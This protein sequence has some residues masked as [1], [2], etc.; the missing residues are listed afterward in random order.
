MQPICVPHVLKLLVVC[1]GVL[2]MTVALAIAAE[3]GYAANATPAIDN[4]GFIKNPPQE[5]VER[6]PMCDAFLKVEWI[7]G[8][9]RLGYSQYSIFDENGG[10]ILNQ[11][12]AIVHLNY[13]NT[14]YDYSARMLPHQ[15]DHLEGQYV[16]S[17]EE[18]RELYPFFRNAKEVLLREFMPG[19]KYKGRV[20]AL[21]TVSDYLERE[22]KF[23][24]PY[25][26]GNHSMNIC[27]QFPDIEL[28]W[29]V[30]QR[31]LSNQ[32]SQDELLKQKQELRNMNF[33]PPRWHGDVLDLDLLGDYSVFDVN[34]DGKEDYV[35]GSSIIYSVDGEY[36]QPVPLWK[37]GNDDT[38]GEYRFPPFNGTCVT[39]PVGSTILTTNGTNYFFDTSCDLTTLTGGI[40]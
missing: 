26:L 4:V 2:M 12:N 14:R 28:V 8:K 31:S 38:I 30:E 10:R 23:D 9:K 24:G 37:S 13:W 19:F 27:I 21:S 15:N 40:N 18:F 20:I 6:F 3:G 17:I 34:F 1:C 5:L 7:D 22:L 36:Y 35:Y 32:M 29:I 11:V 39:N 33:A 25:S 16:W